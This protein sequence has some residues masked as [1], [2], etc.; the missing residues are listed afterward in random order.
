MNCSNCGKKLSEKEIKSNDIIAND[1]LCKGYSR[2]DYCTDCWW[3]YVNHVIS[4]KWI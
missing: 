3:D 2:L 4:K 1:P